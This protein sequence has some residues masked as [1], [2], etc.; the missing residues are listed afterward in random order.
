MIQ[1]ETLAQMPLQFVH[2]LR[3]LRLKQ[4]EQEQQAVEAKSRAAGQPM[5]TSNAMEHLMDEL[6]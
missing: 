5:M 6:T 2:R 3:D 4:L 1:T